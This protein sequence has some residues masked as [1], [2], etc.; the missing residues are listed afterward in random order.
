MLFLL[1]IESDIFLSSS[2]KRESGQSVRFQL[3]FEGHKN[4]DWSRK[5]CRNNVL[6][7]SSVMG[8]YLFKQCYAMLS[9]VFYRFDLIYRH[10]LSNSTRH[11]PKEWNKTRVV[12]I[13]YFVCF[14]WEFFLS[15]ICKHEYN[16]CS[17]TTET[18]PGSPD[19]VT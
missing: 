15:L 6:S 7:L 13:Y 12:M 4:L 19:R 10:S 17:F 14:I 11:K 3:F 2:G 1:M 18:M 8:R 5:I 9:V 16:Q